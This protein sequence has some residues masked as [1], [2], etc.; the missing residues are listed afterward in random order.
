MDGYHVEIDGERRVLENYWNALSLVQ[1]HPNARVSTRHH[2]Q[3]VFLSGKW[4]LFERSTIEEMI[5]LES[6]NSVIEQAT[7]C[8]EAEQLIAKDSRFETHRRGHSKKMLRYVCSTGEDFAVE[9]RPG[10]PLFYLA[11]TA[12]NQQ[13]FKGLIVRTKGP[14]P[15]E[16]NSNLNTIESFTG[17]PLIVLRPN[18]LNE[19]Q[20]ILSLIATSVKKTDVG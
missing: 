18:D 20:S 2:P 8:S 1:A 7:L 14:G 12:K 19:V 16:R 13:K 6:S 10:R 4:K 5:S 9:K 15:T 3:Y 11:S 17:A